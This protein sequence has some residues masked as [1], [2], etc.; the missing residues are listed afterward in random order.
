MLYPTLLPHVIAQDPIPRAVL[1]WRAI[2]VK[3]T[4]RRCGNVNE[5]YKKILLPEEFILKHN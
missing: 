3:Q 4:K 2:Q 1:T 5:Y